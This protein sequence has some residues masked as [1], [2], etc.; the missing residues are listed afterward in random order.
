M[1]VL[2]SLLIEVFKVLLVFIN[3]LMTVVV[4]YSGLKKMFG[5]YLPV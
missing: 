1:L 5:I 4:A 3:M 2:M